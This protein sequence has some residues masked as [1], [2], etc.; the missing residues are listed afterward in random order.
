MVNYWEFPLHLLKTKSCHD[1]NFINIDGTT[2]SHNSNLLY[3]CATSE[4]KV[5]I[6]LIQFSLS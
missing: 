2:G 6:I 4:V 3:G 5:G 1:A